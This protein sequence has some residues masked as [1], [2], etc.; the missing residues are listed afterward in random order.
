M[1]QKLGLIWKV[2][3]QEVASSGNDN[4]H[5]TLNDENR[6]PSLVLVD[7]DVRKTV[8]KDSSKS[9]NDV[10]DGKEDGYAL[11]RLMARV[12]RTELRESG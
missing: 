5:E 4:G 6:A 2:A 11:L 7:L 10:R 3:D 8:P 1:V 9:S 12:P